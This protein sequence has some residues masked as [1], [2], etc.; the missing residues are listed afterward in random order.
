MTTP[1]VG[2]PD[3]G[4]SNNVDFDALEQQFAQPAPED[5]PAPVPQDLHA[6]RFDGE[7]VPEGIRGMSAAQLAER[8]ANLERAL[9]VSEQAR[10]GNTQAQPAYTAPAEAP[11]PQFTEAQ[12]RELFESDPLAAMAALTQIAEQRASH[13]FNQRISQLQQGTRGAVE[14]QV[15]TK[16]AE[17]FELFGAEIDAVAKTVDPAVLA[18]PQAW[19]QMIAYVRGQNVDKVVEKRV[20]Q[21]LAKAQ[22]LTREAA[23]EMQLGTAPARVT[24][25][26]QPSTPQNNHGL[27][28]TQLEICNIMGI[29]PADY[30]KY[31]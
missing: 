30:R 23:Q 29:S 25:Q 24:T 3:L 26:R 14:A 22:G 5:N 1:N 12:L 8:A 17:D 27:D 4:T 18:N 11:V 15:R 28:A 10:L 20:K 9:K 16:F 7:G 2:V 21:E 19:E 6:I 13:T 31:S